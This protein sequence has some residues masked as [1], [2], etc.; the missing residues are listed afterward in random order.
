MSHPSARLLLTDDPVNRIRD[1]A[2]PIHLSTTF[3]YP[4]NPD[5]LIPSEGPVTTPL[6]AQKPTQPNKTCRIQRQ[7]L[8]LRA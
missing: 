7:D 3:R 6:T 4:D 8:H 5:Q 1:V 2:P